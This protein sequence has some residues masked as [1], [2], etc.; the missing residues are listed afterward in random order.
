MRILIIEDSN[1]LARVL[2]F[3]LKKQHDCII[4]IAPD[5]ATAKT[6]FEINDYFVAITDLRLPDAENGESVEL[7]LGNGIPCIVLTG[8][9]DH[10]QRQRLLQ[11]G[12]VDYVYKENKFSYEYVVKLVST[13]QRNI[14]TK[15]LV[16]DDSIVSR[17]ILKNLL[18]QQLFDV[19]D[20]DSGEKALTLLQ[21]LSGIRLLITDY[22]MPGMDGFELIL[23][24][25]E[26][27]SREELA[28]IGLSNEGNES[29]TARFIKNGAN[30][31]LQKPV[32]HEEFLCRVNNTLD[33]LDMIKKLWEL[34]NLD[35]LTGIFNRRY[36]LSKLKELWGT[37]S[38]QG[39]DMISFVK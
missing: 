18:K 2:Q 30:D 23:R 10:K 28:I 15:V 14:D 5:L 34:A 22:N 27:F 24:V 25:R 4:D 7:V 36:F 6:L 8:S 21:D 3:M 9:L 20:V 1:V 11:M 29:L 16:V 26:K 33:S 19:V 31:F 39:V 38:Y 37:E 13:L 32:V 12:I 35:Y 17:K